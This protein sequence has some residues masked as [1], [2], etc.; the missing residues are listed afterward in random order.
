[1]T[2]WELYEKGKEYN[3]RHNY[4]TNVDRNWRVYNLEHLD[5][6]N[7]KN[8]QK[9]TMPMAQRI[10]DQAVATCMT[11]TVKM[12]YVVENISDKSEDPEDKKR[13][14]IARVLSQHSQEKWETLTMDSLIRDTLLDGANSGDMAWHTYWDPTYDTGQT[15]GETYV[16]DKEGNPQFDEMGNPIME[17][18]PILGD[19]WTEAVDG[20]NIYF[21]NPNDRRI[22][23]RGKPRQPYVIVAGRDTV[24]SLRDEATEYSKSQNGHKKENKLSADDIKNL[25]VP[26]EDYLEQAGDSGKKEL[27]AKDEYGKATYII[28]YW[29][30]DGKIHFNK[31]VKGCEIRGHVNTELTLYPVAWANWRKKKNSYHG[32][33]I[34]TGLVNNQ[35]SLDKA[36]MLF[37]YYINNMA[38]P[39]AIA[40]KHFFPNGVSNKAGDVIY[41]DGMETVSPNN[42]L[43]YTQPAQMAN[44]IIDLL[45]IFR[46]TT[47][48][49]L[50]AS[51]SVLGNANPENTSAIVANVQNSI[52]PLENV[53]AHLHQLVED[54]GY[55]WNDFQLHK[56]I[57][58][59]NIAIDNNG[60]REMVMFDPSEF[61][62]AKFRIKVDVISGSYID[63]FTAMRAI[64]NLFLQKQIDVIQFIE[65][66]PD[67]MIPEKEKLITE[68]R[69]KITAE[70]NFQRQL[71]SQEHDAQ[72]IADFMQ[73][74][75]EKLQ[76]PAV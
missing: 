56:F 72:V 8:L 71:M 47:M 51:D 55:I 57:V 31:S 43:Q 66:L 13:L 69:A 62:K 27:D 7:L 4:N 18:V 17:P 36:W 15:A 49:L 48:D 60:T 29:P 12:N 26:D 53:K 50:G 76:Q 59:R 5:S 40:N 45:E 73:K 3:A 28:K 54:Q 10:V 65:R 23:F 35:I 34:M 74:T 41:Y 63:E 39:K 14:T 6:L 16:L 38:L 9:V 68:L 21:G 70:Q 67:G 20:G 46:K 58:P 32:Q 33:A 2:D 25:I 61:S 11:K 44:G 1:M 42:V 52:I 64:E 37:M 19:F 75:T 22:N 30:K 24:Q